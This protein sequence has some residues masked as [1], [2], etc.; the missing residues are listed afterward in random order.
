MNCSLVCVSYMEWPNETKLSDLPL[1]IDCAGQKLNFNCTWYVQYFSQFYSW[2][3]VV[4]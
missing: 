4:Q 3:N 2:Q 1:Y